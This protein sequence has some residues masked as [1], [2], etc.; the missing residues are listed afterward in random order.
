M[1]TFEMWCFSTAENLFHA[2]VSCGV[3][4]LA[5]RPHGY[6]FKKYKLCICILWERERGRAQMTW[7]EL[8]V[9]ACLRSMGR[10]NAST[11][12]CRYRDGILK[13]TKP[14]PP[15][16]ERASR[17]TDRIE[18]DMEDN[19]TKQEYIR[20]WSYIRLSLEFY[21]LICTHYNRFF[22]DIGLFKVTYMRFLPLSYFNG[23][24]P[25]YL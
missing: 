3:L 22:A 4:N 19:D 18:Q 16:W 5:C 7:K 20:V 15:E 21:E 2:I 9:V 10:I 8:W 1:R 17:S 23:N 14:M 11:H 13:D 24:V 25:H 6:F 12:T